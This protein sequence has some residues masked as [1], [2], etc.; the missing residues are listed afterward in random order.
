MSMKEEI[1][2]LE[3]KK[4]SLEQELATYESDF[5]IISGMKEEFSKIYVIC[6]N[7]NYALQCFNDSMNKTY[8]IKDNIKIDSFEKLFNF[9]ED[10]INKT[11]QVN[12][13]NNTLMDEISNYLPRFDSDL[14]IIGN[15]VS[16]LKH[17]I[18]STINAIDSLRNYGG[19]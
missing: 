16:D 17:S 4:E 12:T 15:K 9:A 14:E 11:S 8:E 19:Q 6:E 1:K 18:T 13:T 3:I 10:K 5:R 7:S 2:K